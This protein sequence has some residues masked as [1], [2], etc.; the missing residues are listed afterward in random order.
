V[1]LCPACRTPDLCA[2]DGCRR[3]P[4][5]AL[6]PAY[7]PLRPILLPGLQGISGQSRPSPFRRLMQRWTY[8]PEGDPGTDP[9][10]LHEQVLA[11][12]NTAA[13]PNPPPAPTQRGPLRHPEPGA[14][15]TIQ[16][17]KTG[18]AVL[19]LGGELYDAATDAAGLADAV[20]AWYDGA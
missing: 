17:C 19:I 14:K 16:I 7:S 10:P 1:P 15:L 8:G 13:D 12:M 2:Y 20:R 9:R 5:T 3:Q 11:V 4:G 6:G 18:A